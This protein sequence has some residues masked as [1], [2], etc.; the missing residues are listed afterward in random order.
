MK[1]T[2]NETE[3]VKPS[4]TIDVEGLN[5]PLPLL[6]IKKKLAK[7]SLGDILQINGILT[8]FIADFEGWCARRGHIF[9]GKK[10]LHGK[11]VFFVKNG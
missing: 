4:S 6:L 7:L 2:S 3:E 1:I 9:L 5:C 8:S 11:K 10:E